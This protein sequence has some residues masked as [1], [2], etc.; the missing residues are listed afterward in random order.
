LAEE[1]QSLRLMS[2]DHKIY[3]GG[4]E[5]AIIVSQSS[6]P[7]DFAASLTDRVAN[8]VPFSEIDTPIRSVNSYT[9]TIGIYPDSLKEE[10]RDRLVFN[11]AQRLTSLGYMLKAA[12]AGPHDGIEP[13][14]RMCKWIIDESND[15]ARVPLPSVA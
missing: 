7:V 13:V 8:L 1:L 2:E 12:M 10:I 15:P 9:Q 11:G 6:E 14:R 3:G 4:G 5:G